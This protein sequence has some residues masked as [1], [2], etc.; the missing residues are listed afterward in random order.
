MS[1]ATSSVGRKFPSTAP[2]RRTPRRAARGANA[3][4]REEEPS[5]PGGAVTRQALRGC[6]DP[7]ATAPLLVRCE[8]AAN[9]VAQSVAPSTR[10]G[11]RVSHTASAG[12]RRPLPI[13]RARAQPSISLP[14]SS[15]EY[16]LRAL[17][18]ELRLQP[19]CDLYRCVP[20]PLPALVQTRAS[21]AQTPARLRS[22]SDLPAEYFRPAS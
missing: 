10:R 4:S 15:P 1:K 11:Q 17:A 22:R 21:N 18:S 3:S 16:L 13:A 9:P 7:R 2:R 20:P 5:F 14:Q 19:W 8:H 6:L 12:S